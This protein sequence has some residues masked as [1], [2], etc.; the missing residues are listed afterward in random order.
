MNPTKPNQVAQHA[1]TANDNKIL[2]AA[3]LWARNSMANQHDRDR[4]IKRLDKILEKCQPSMADIS[5]MRSLFP[6]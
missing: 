1:E 6:E 2:R 5:Y 4:V 3:L